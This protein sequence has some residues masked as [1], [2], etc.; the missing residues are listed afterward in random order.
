MG[1]TRDCKHGQLARSCEICELEADLE[2]QAEYVKELQARLAWAQKTLTGR[3]RRHYASALR[4]LRNF[5]DGLREARALYAEKSGKPDRFDDPG[6]WWQNPRDKCVVLWLLEWAEDVQGELMEQLGK[7]RDALAAENKRLRE[8][9]EQWEWS[10]QLFDDGE[11]HI[12]YCPACGKLQRDGHEVDCW[13][14]AALS[15]QP[16]TASPSE[17]KGDSSELERLRRAVRWLHDSQSRSISMGDASSAGR[18]VRSTDGRWTRLLSPNPHSPEATMSDL[19][20]ADLEAMEQRADNGNQRRSDIYA[21]IAAL[22]DAQGERKQEIHLVFDGPPEHVA[23][24]FVEAENSAGESISVGRWEQ[25]GEYWHLII[26]R[27]A[28]V[29][30]VKRLEKVAE[31]AR[32][33][34]SEHRADFM[35]D[36][37]RQDRLYEL[38]QLLDESDEDAA[39]AELDAGEVCGG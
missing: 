19:T 17:P 22:R 29:A 2:S 37:A 34:R 31:A 18:G 13:M 4:Q 24:R 16:P 11:T 7:E 8:A 28:E 27:A 12:T 1:A 5:R 9:L 33:L 32:A 20:D 23:G 25:R 30:R 36:G 6:A 15:P 38:F 3:Q 26:P 14:K 10:D 35:D 21:L 39:L